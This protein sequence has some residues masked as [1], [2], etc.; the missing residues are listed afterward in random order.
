M[1]TV[2]VSDIDV[3]YTEAG[4]GPPVV[5]VHGL[6][7]ARSSWA[8]QHRDLSSVHT[9]AYDLRGHGETTLGN[10]D[11]TLEQLGGDLIGFLEQVTGPATVVGF[12]LGGTI[13]LWAA[14][15]RPD[16]MQRVIVLG[17]SSVVGRAAAAFYGQR[18]GEAADTS[19]PEFHVALREDTAAA[20]VAA[21]DRVEEVLGAR[22]AAVGDGRGYINAA[23][24]MA[25]LHEAP[26]TAR[27][28][29]IKV[30]VDVVGA[31]GDTFCPQKA[32]RILLDG[33]SDATYY[34]VSD[35]GHLV[36]VDQPD[37][38]TELLDNLLHGREG[39]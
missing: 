30:H 27:L 16:L 35:A 25:A 32:A 39:R 20:I 1:S 26:L 23:R 12:S 8:V 7:E 28:G 5:L 11:G 37:A 29:E 15:E 18:I 14:A 2:T 38:V 24:A 21:N 9:F 22:L 34:E 4:A 17:T 31:S 19:S 13:A 3:A 6:A 10:A 36:N 33:L